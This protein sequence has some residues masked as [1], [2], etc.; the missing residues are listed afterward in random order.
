MLTPLTPCQTIDEVIARLDQMIARCIQEQSKLGYF[1]AL[2]RNVTVSVRDGIAAGRFEDGPRMERFDVAFANRYFEAFDR[3]WREEQTTQSWRVAFHAASQWSPVILQHL[4]LGMSAHI[5]LD[6]AIAA[7]E[8]A[9]GE[10]LP[11]LKKDFFEITV[12]LSELID[13]VQER[14]D[15][16]SPWFRLIDRLGGRTDER[17][18]AFAIA[19]VRE[20]AW[21]MAEALASLPTEAFEQL[22]AERDQSVAEIGNLIRSPGLLL[23]VGLWL[24]RAREIHPIPLVIR[25]LQL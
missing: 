20:E 9:P 1:A 23:N 10:Q 8:I 24:V 19:E 13:S 18:C 11:G 14:I 7:A 15:Q 6:L 17:L 21:K 5:N 25:T 16:V 3:A 12:L 2:Y 22:V 4:L